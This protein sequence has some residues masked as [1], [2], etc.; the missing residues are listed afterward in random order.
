MNSRRRAGK[1]HRHIC[2]TRRGD[3]GIMLLD[4][5]SGEDLNDYRAQLPSVGRKYRHERHLKRLK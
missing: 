1:R 4:D 3:C 2:F 5:C